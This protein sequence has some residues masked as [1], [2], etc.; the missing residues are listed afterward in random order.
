MKDTNVWSDASAH[1]AAFLGNVQAGVPISGE[2]L[3]RLIALT[4]S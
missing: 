1:V 3:E 2:K 4:S